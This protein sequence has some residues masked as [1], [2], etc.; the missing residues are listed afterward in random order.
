MKI[1]IAGSRNITQKNKVFASIFYGLASFVT[2]NINPLKNLEIVSGCCRG[3][4]KIG[5]EFADFF[6]IQKRLFP[7]DWDKYGKRAGYI[8]NTE[9]ANYADALIAIWD[10][11]SKG[12]KMMI[13]IAKEKGLKIYAY[14]MS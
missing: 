4:D 10:G 7:A 2:E 11:E 9:M 5:E 13:N 8:R 1:I 12:T 6:K 3:V 14:K